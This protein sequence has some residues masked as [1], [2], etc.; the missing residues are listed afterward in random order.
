MNL[1]Q[2]LAKNIAAHKDGTDCVKVACLEFL[3]AIRVTDETHWIKFY[4]VDNQKAHVDV[5]VRGYDRVRRSS[6]DASFSE[7]FTFTFL[8]SDP[9]CLRPAADAGGIVGMSNNRMVTVREELISHLTSPFVWR[10]RNGSQW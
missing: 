8:M 6:S 9:Q 7:T 4:H 2:V 10:S 5:W 3:N 1:A